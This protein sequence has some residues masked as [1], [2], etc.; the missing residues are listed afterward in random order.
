MGVSIHYCEYYELVRQDK[1]LV[2]IANDG[3]SFT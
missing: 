1:Q 2:I 3:R